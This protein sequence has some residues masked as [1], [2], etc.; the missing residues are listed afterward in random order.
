VS[1]SRK[2]GPPK[3]K[4]G[5]ATVLFKDGRQFVADHA[6]LVGSALTFSGRQRERTLAGDRYLK[7]Q[8]RT[9]PMRAVLAIHW[10]K[11]VN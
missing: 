11:V 1:T 5:R 2:K 7:I 8:T 3:S 9:V 6:E 4:A 10:H